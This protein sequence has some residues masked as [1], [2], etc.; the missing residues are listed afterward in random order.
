MKHLL[1]LVLFTHLRCFN[2]KIR[3]IIFVKDFEFDFV[4][5]LNGDHIGWIDNFCLSVIIGG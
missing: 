1:K 5:G 2:F 4:I 3:I